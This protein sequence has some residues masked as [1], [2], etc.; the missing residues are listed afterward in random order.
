MAIWDDLLTP[1]DREVLRLSGYGTR[2][3][4]GEKPAVLVVDVTYNFTGERSE[5]IVDAVRRSRNACGAEAWT[6]V[7]SIR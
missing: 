2:Q 7:G 5:P 1:L 3:G 4:L 6:A